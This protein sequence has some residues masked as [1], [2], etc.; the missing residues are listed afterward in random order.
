[1]DLNNLIKTPEPLQSVGEQLK[2]IKMN[3][4]APMPARISLSNTQSSASPEKEGLL[5]SLKNRFMNLTSRTEVFSSA[6]DKQ[7][8]ISNYYNVPIPGT[9][10]EYIDIINQKAKQY[11]ISPGVLSS[12]LQAES[13]FNPN[14]TRVS[15]REKSYGL[16]QINTMAHPITEKQA[17]DPAFAIDFAAKRLAEMIQKYGLNKGI[18]AYNTP[19]SIGSQQLIDYANKVLKTA[20]TTQSSQ[21]TKPTSFNKQGG[22][23]IGKLTSLGKLTTEYGTPTRY[24]KFHPGIDIAN[25]KGTSIPSVT[26]GI[27][28]KVITGKRH[29]DKGFG[30]QVIITDADGNK[31]QYSHLDT[32]LAKEGQSV[33]PGQVVAT[34]GDTGSTYSPSGQGTGTHLDYRIVSAYNKYINPYTYSSKQV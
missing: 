6:P 9:P 8:P 4:G 10:T 26:S 21:N 28:T 14:A 34:M 7:Q 2:A 32:V 1:M 16:A 30:N 27:I 31:H 29:G 3:M 20:T 13:S 15:K 17:K 23:P 19:G 5:S 11:G 22:S 25:V 33:S 18:Q 24:E 12:L